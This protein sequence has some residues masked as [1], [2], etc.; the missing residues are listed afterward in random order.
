MHAFLASLI[1]PRHALALYLIS[2]T[3]H[4]GAAAPP[5]PRA[6]LVSKGQSQAV[7]V[8]ESHQRTRLEFD[9]YYD[10][11]VKPSFDAASVALLETYDDPQQIHATARARITPCALPPDNRA[12]ERL[13]P[14]MAALAEIIEKNKLPPPVWLKDW[15]MI[16]EFVLAS[17]ML[18]F[19][20]PELYQPVYAA[21]RKSK[22]SLGVSWQLYSDAFNA[23][24]T[25]KLRVLDT[26]G[27]L[28]QH[29]CSS[30]AAERQDYVVDKINRMST[31]LRRRY[32]DPQL[33]LLQDLDNK[34]AGYMM[35]SIACVDRA[36]PCVFGAPSANRAYL[37][38]WGL[39]LDTT[40]GNFSIYLKRR[41][42][43]WVPIIEQAMQRHQ[44]S[45]VM[46]GSLHLPDLRFK[47]SIEPGLISLLRKNGYAIRPI[48]SAVD[49]KDYLRP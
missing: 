43:A 32:A 40:D 3:A 8:G 9:G 36:Q 7:L 10:S 42:H 15:K 21:M 30:S 31:A 26:V 25:S 5:P 19:V 11:V 49:L 23:K 39:A 33:A 13:A 41:T 17:L 46:V 6:W 37:L 35:E 29:F 18:D 34:A 44:R 27:S 1:R 38:A 47:Q 16:P 24:H 14:A 28:R 48:S 45:F 22:F 20:T 4:A 12:T 2:L